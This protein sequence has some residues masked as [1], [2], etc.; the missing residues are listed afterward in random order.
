MRPSRLVLLAGAAAALMGCPG[1]GALRIS[2]VSGGGGGVSASRLAFIVQ[3]SSAL[4]DVE[5]APAL[6][7]AA[8]DAL[9]TIDTTFSGGVTVALGANPGGALLS[10]TKTVV[11][12][13]GVATFANLTLDQ[14]G[15]GYTLTATAIGLN[16]TTSGSFT[17]VSPPAGGVTQATPWRW[18]YSPSP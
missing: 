13:G 4:T 6:Q 15:T 3:P 8:Q 12:T 5:I 16:G 2:G 11:A 18:G 1:R 10:G 14:P 7:V 9:G 17:I